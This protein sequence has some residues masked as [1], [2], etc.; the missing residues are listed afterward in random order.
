MPIT[1]GF[2]RRITNFPILNAKNGV[3]VSFTETV[4]MG[5]FFHAY[6][7]LPISKKIG[8]MLLISAFFGLSISGLMGYL[9]GR[10]LLEE[11]TVSKL[12][13]IREI[14]KA[15]LELY[16]QQAEITLKV[17]AENP[18]T[19]EA[20]LA[21]KAAFHAPDPDMMAS[22]VARHQEGL[23]RYYQLEFAPRYNSNAATRIE[24]KS[25]LPND[26]KA[27][28]WQIAYISENHN[29]TGKKHHLNANKA[30]A[31]DAAYHLLHER[32]HSFFRTCL[33]NYGF[34][35]IFLVDNRTGHIVYSV[36][37]EIDYATSLLDGPHAHSNIA[38][39][40]RKAQ[41]K[42]AIAEFVC[43]DFDEYAP[44]Y[45]APA[46]FIGIPIVENGQQLGVLI[47]QLPIDQVN[48]I[49]SGFQRW[50]EIGLG[51]TGETFVVGKDRLMR[52]DARGV[53][54]SPVEFIGHMEQLNQP[55]GALKR[56]EALASTIFLQQVATPGVE[57]AL[58]GKTGVGIY[59][60]YHQREVLSSY[61][62]LNVY[63]LGWCIVSEMTTREAFQPIQSFKFFLLLVFVLMIFITM[64][65]GTWL[66]RKIAGPIKTATAHIVQ[67]SEGRNP[68]I[69]V[70][71]TKDEIGLMTRSLKKLVD[72]LDEAARF[73][74]AVGT[75]DFA[76]QYQARCEE[77]VLG[78]SLISM[79]NDLQQ[80]ETESQKRNRF[81]E[82]LAQL[83]EI[84][85]KFT[86]SEHLFD[87]SLRFVIKNVEAQQGALYVKQ[88]S[89][90]RGEG[91]YSLVSCYALDKKKYLTL[92]V[93][94]GIGLVGQAIIEK[95]MLVLSQVPASYWQIVTGTGQAQPGMLVVIPLM[96]MEQV[97]GALEIASLKPI[98]ADDRDLLQQFADL[99]AST[100]ASEITNAKIK[101]M[102]LE[103]QT[104]V[105][106]LR[107]Q[108]EEMRQNMEELLATQE[109]MERRQRDG[110]HG[111][112]YTFD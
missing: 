5:N 97:Y 102:L 87:Q 27:K 43:A 103:N 30:I 91:V 56:M 99:M 104:I 107:T 106:Q 26:L 32:Y 10:G 16:F 98:S 46:M 105:E 100:I 96:V 7:N 8:Y 88:E 15:G 70:L 90:Q 66:A 82:G 47:I 17:L 13:S 77:D 39:V 6:Q 80:L 53:A 24:G 111:D 109:E 72:N 61:S 14:K 81:T 59:K 36:F 29:P 44:S 83:G 50:Q 31:P 86:G 101:A 49:L 28:F 65:L 95:E 4:T 40:F 19:K 62:P 37:K 12:T 1:F 92:T 41:S 85:R 23:L 84:L 9:Q 94:P 69:A 74:R 68:A 112:P 60:S 48:G 110:Q 76:F 64:G 25:M 108:E 38:E 78:L 45:T 89:G 57:A 54:E 11:A 55:S 58:V 22:Q 33:E 79:R 75:R 35:D 93:E 18:A 51:I 42:G 52:S 73:A 21:F 71:E 34:Y 63:G 2:F 67:I 3:K 20:M